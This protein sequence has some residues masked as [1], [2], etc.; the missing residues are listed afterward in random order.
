MNVLMTWDGMILMEIG[1]M[2]MALGMKSWVV[3]RFTPSIG[4]QKRLNVVDIVQLFRPY[5]KANIDTLDSYPRAPSS[6][7]PSGPHP[8]ASYPV[9]D[10]LRHTQCHR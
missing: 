3:C 10:S 1:G 5:L 9:S 2:A 4:E 7:T 8:L 6:R